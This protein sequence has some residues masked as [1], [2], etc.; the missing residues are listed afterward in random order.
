MSLMMAL[1]LGWN[2][3]ASALSDLCVNDVALHGG[4]ANLHALVSRENP[5]A[6]RGEGLKSFEIIRRHKMFMALDNNVRTTISQAQC[7]LY[8]SN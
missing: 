6:V 5:S 8:T 2:P 1:R 3:C 7:S 4:P